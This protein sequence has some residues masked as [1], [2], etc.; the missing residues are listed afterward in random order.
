MTAIAPVARVQPEPRH[1]Q[2]IDRSGPRADSS[3]MD[4]IDAL[5]SSKFGGFS[6]TSRIRGEDRHARH[7]VEEGAVP[8]FA[9]A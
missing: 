9:A 4:L 1:K 2:L 7:E 5:G 6:T 3:E 8:G